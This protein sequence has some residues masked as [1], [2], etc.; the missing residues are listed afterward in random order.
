MHSGIA[1]IAGVGIALVLALAGLMFGTTTGVVHAVGCNYINLSP[2]SGKVGTRVAASGWFGCSA[3]SS[4]QL[5]LVPGNAA[6]AVP[7]GKLCYSESAR[8]CSNRTRRRQREVC[9]LLLVAGRCGQSGS[10]E[11]LRR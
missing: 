2:M 11:H 3:P 4:L 7:G 10:E 5:Y 1:T 8:Q 6:N 9:C